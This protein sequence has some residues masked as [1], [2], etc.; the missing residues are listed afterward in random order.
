MVKHRG[1]FAESDEVR[2]AKQLHDLFPR[3]SIPLSWV[4][5][6]SPERDAWMHARATSPDYLLIHRLKRWW[7]VRLLGAAKRENS[8][9]AY[10]VLLEGLLIRLG[11]EAPEGVFVPL[12]GSPGAPRKKTTEQIYRTWIETGRPK[13]AML[14]YSVYGSDY[15]R[16]DGKG[17]KRIRD[18]CGQ[19]LKRY[20]QQLATKSAPK[21]IVSSSDD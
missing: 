4:M 16:A 5:K 1:E 11:I 9:E 13:L 2:S 19:A 10:R 20:Q 3:G 7:L 17:R 14:A 15:I 18:R 12:P 6:P 8:P 21:H